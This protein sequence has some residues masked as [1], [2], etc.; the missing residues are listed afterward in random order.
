MMNHLRWSLFFSLIIFFSA[1]SFAVTLDQSAIEKQSFEIEKKIKHD[2]YLMYAFTTVAFVHEVCQWAPVL[3][4]LVF[5]QSTGKEAPK[6]SFLQAMKSGAEHLFLTQEGWISLIQSS[7]SVGGFVII[8]Q[9]GEKF[10]HPDTL[11]WYIHACA[12]YHLAIQLMKEQISNIQDPLYDQDQ[13]ALSKEMI[14]MLRD[15]LIH[16]AENM[17]AY[18]TYKIKHLRDAEKL[19]AE[20]SKR[21][22]INSHVCALSKLEEELYATNP[23]YKKIELLLESYEVI[24]AAQ[25]EHFALLE[26]ETK[27][28]RVAI[29]RRIKQ[30]QY[31][32]YE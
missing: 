31:G 24:I 25:V 3:K 26:G 12:P 18:I 22:M 6:L 1:P 7:F 23:D 11:R 20:R 13:H 10:I 27:R 2:R 9:M 29:K 28:E 15:R 30:Q 5:G 21:S 19:V 8:S 14:N 32:L 17:C 16:Y 4:D